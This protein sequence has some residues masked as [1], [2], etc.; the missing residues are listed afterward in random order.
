MKVGVG[1]L[2]HVPPPLGAGHCVGSGAVHPLAPSFAV[3]WGWKL[4]RE[5]GEDAGGFLQ[6]IPPMRGWGHPALVV[7]SELGN[8]K[9]RG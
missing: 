3:G 5:D 6:V 4:R 2:S 7:I 8:G 1:E 9:R